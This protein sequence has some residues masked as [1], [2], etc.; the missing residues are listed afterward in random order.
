MQCEQE[1]AGEVSDDTARWEMEDE[2]VK[3]T[4]VMDELAQWS[5]NQN[6]PQKWK[7]PPCGQPISAFGSDSQKDLKMRPQDDSEFRVVKLNSQITYF[8]AF[9]FR[10][11]CADHTYCTL[12][13]P[14]STTAEVIKVSAADKL[15]L[16]HDD[17]VLVEV[18]SSGT[19]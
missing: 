9:I 17:L 6:V 19:R 15:G 18:K 8:P 12:R 7:L 1:L 3:M 5:A 4:Q 13:F 11:Y 14:L 16:K 2:N 10:V